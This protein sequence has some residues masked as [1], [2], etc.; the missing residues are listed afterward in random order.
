MAPGFF[1]EFEIDYHEN[2]SLVVK[3]IFLILFLFVAT[4]GFE[5]HQMD[6]CITI[7]NDILHEKI[8]M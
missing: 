1:Q 5:I 6:V 8:F 2:V 7:L 4:L 3:L